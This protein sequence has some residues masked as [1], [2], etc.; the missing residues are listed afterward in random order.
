M[1]PQLEPQPVLWGFLEMGDPSE[2]PPVGP[3]YP[4]PHQAIIEPR[5]PGEGGRSM[6]KV[7]LFSRGSALC[8]GRR[9][10]LQQP[11]K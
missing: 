9:R 11:A 1:Q 2:L 4:S 7:A 6:G 3:L 5:L 10:P 8:R